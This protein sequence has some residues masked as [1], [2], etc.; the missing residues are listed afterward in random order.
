MSKRQSMESMLLMVNM[1]T[2][3]FTNRFGLA[4]TITLCI[5][6]TVNTSSVMNL[7]DQNF[8]MVLKQRPMKNVL[9]GHTAGSRGQALLFGNKMITLRLTAKMVRFDRILENELILRR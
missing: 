8:T 9:P 6:K 1:K 3:R 2:E 7:D 4:K 5:S